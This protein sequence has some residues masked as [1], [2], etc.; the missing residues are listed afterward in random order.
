MLRKVTVTG[1]FIALTLLLSCC[2][3]Q[4]E[5]RLETSTSE[6][7]V[8]ETK[9]FDEN[10][11]PG[12]W[13]N[14]DNPE[15]LYS[16]AFVDGPDQDKIKVSAI[17][18]AQAKLLHNKKSYVVNLTELILKE[19]D[20]KDKFK[21]N[22]LNAKNGLIYNKDYSQF[23]KRTETDFIS[24]D[25][26][27]FRCFVAI[28]LPVEAIE[29][30][31]V[32]QFQKDKNMAIA[33]AGSESYRNLLD[34]TGLKATQAGNILEEKTAK[35]EAKEIDKKVK[36]EDTPTN[37]YVDVIPAWYK[38]SYNNL[39]VMVNQSSLANKADKAEEEAIKQCKETKMS[40]ANDFARAQ[41]ERYREA[42]G[43]DVIKFND[44]KNKISE[45]VKKNNYP[46]NK[47]FVKT[48]QI[49]EDSY[50]TYAQY[51]LNKQ[52]IQQSLVKV[53]KTDD[54]LYSRLRASMTFDELDDQDF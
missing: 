40:F 39:K 8:L 45:E 37:K 28:G 38:I 53:L 42:S 22:S 13:E 30:E 31:F 27:D 50:K 43:Y 21:S 33:F 6:T 1:Y 46:I 7:S 47:E 25:E 24:I 4:I 9:T 52:A 12:W 11:R 5:K 10:Y 23:L 35:E 51:S 3:S 20:S 16:Y 14:I 49:G 26:T 44:L 41:A 19:S 17:N 32:N 36:E 54:I 48:I 2:N 34:K 29:K 18:S 15:Y